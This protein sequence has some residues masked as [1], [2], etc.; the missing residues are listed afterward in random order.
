MIDS[1]TFVTRHMMADERPD[2]WI[3]LDEYKSEGGERKCIMHARFG[4]FTP[5]IYKRYFRA[6]KKLAELNY[7]LPI[8]CVPID[9]QNP[10]AAADE[11]YLKFISRSGYVPT[12]VF[13]DRGKQF[14]RFDYGHFNTEHTNRSKR[15]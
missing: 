7:G 1:W 9:E 4:Q 2:F 15:D 3:E 14:Y 6:I 13:T 12:G 5:A 10:D 8:F 11:K